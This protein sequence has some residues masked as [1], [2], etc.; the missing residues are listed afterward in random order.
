MFKCNNSTAASKETTA[1]NRVKRIG[2]IWVNFISY[3]PFFTSKLSKLK[4]SL[5]NNGPPC[6]CLKKS[7][8]QN[9]HGTQ[10]S[11]RNFKKQSNGLEI[12]V[13]WKWSNLIGRDLS[14]RFAQNFAKQEFS[15]AYGRCTIHPNHNVQHISLF[16]AK[17]N[18]SIL[19]K[20]WNSPLLGHFLPFL[21]KF[22]PTEFLPKN[23]A[24]SLLFIF[25]VNVNRNI[26]SSN[27]KMNFEIL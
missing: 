9:Y 26:V 16:P 18:D 3:Q 5:M 20:C 7:Q 25:P 2:K 14:G 21:P 19:R 10:A 8:K 27:S 12:I 11:Y 13:F 24:L 6:Y 17:C 22:G 15:Q 1:T 23:F 4:Q